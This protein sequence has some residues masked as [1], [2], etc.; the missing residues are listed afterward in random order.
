[1][2]RKGW[3]A[4]PGVQEG[5][6]T[7]EDQIAAVRPALAGCAGK[8]VLDL[9]CAE[10]LIALEFA[11]AGARRVLG[12]DGVPGNICTALETARAEPVEFVHADL[13]TYV[14]ERM[15]AGPERFDLVL[16]LGI[17]HKLQD[18]ATAMRFAAAS[19]GELLLL[20]GGRCLVNGIIARK[21]RREITVDAHAIL[22]GAGFR[23]EKTVTGPAPHCEDVEYWRRMA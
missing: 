6:R 14:P 15:A 22:V 8:T 12:I 20:R 10:G 18:P 23:L 1:M 13:N 2:D 21:R 3:F 9:G 11:R 16:A 19:A 7:L 17:I 4:I 5:A